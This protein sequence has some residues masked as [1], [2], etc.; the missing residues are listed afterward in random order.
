M[1]TFSLIALAVVAL[2]GLLFLLS[3]G[4]VIYV[5]W[6]LNKAMKRAEALEQEVKGLR[7]EVNAMRGTPPALP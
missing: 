3:I 7:E 2:M 1:S 6:L 4:V 5:V